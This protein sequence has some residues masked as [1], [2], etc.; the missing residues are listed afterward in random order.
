MPIWIVALLV[1]Q[2]QKISK[3]R[4]Y[5][6]IDRRY[7]KKLTFLCSS[8]W[9]LQETTI[10]I[11]SYIFLFLDLVTQNK[12]SIEEHNDMCLSQFWIFFGS[13]LELFLRPWAAAYIISNFNVL[14]F[15]FNIR[16]I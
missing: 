15:N 9:R 2:Y 14:V 1:L 4:S 10:T 12:V 16:L 3:T 5:V 8:S 7:H 6:Y 11:Y 13:T